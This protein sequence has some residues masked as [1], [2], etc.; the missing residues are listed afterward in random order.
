MEGL[1]DCLQQCWAARR[2]EGDYSDGAPPEGLGSQR[3]GGRKSDLEFGLG[4]QRVIGGEGLGD[5]ERLGHRSRGR[6]R[7]RHT[8]VEHPRWKSQ[9]PGPSVLGKRLGRPRGGPG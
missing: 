9:H 7:V 6:Q 1:W 4:A 2:R 5:C 8:R 3:A